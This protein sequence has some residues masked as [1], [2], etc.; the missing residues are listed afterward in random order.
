MI[1]REVRLPSAVPALLGALSL[2]V[3]PPAA[4]WAKPSQIL[5]CTGPADPAPC[6]VEGGAPD[7]SHLPAA[8][9]AAWVS[10]NRLVISWVGEA[11]EVRMTGSIHLR[12]PMPS[13]APG[14]RQFVVQYPKARQTRASLNFAVKH[15]AATIRQRVDLVGPAA[16]TL[17]GTAAQ[18]VQTIDFGADAPE[19]R[20]W[21]PP[22]YTASRRYPIVYLADGGWTSPGALLSES[23][24]K[25]E[26]APSIVVGVDYSPRDREDADS[27]TRTYIGI[28]GGPITPEF[29]AHE[30]FLVDTVVP[31]IEA[32]YG[33]PPER[34]LR[35]V[36]GASNG[37]VWT[38]S[39]A[40]RNPGTFGTAFV[41][42]AGMLPAQHGAGRSSVRFHVA[43]GDIEPGF[44]WASSCIAGEIVARGGIA[45][46]TT[47]PSGHDSAMWN[48]MLLDQVRDWLGPQQSAVLAPLPDA[49]CKRLRR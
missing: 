36:G 45:T 49:S 25:G 40:L 3:L 22:G 37:G 42:S 8:G 44:R 6:L 9:P 28:P 47:Y 1:E 5:P 18:Q 38:A 46:F 39:M 23:I 32:R 10:E 43:A 11:D 15:G 14:L 17:P 35:A 12:P 21:L 34:R 16:F 2:L 27:R 24:R 30:R 7:R 26:L 13:V 19:A 20:V 41:M 33:A 48:R 31:A 29:L 4:A